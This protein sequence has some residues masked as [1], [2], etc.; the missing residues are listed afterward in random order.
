M[1]TGRICLPREGLAYLAEVKLSRSDRFVVQQL[2]AELE[3][4]KARLARVGQGVKGV[5]WPGGAGGGG[6]PQVVGARFLESVR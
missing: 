4:H 2:L 3:C 6:S 5:Y 1:L